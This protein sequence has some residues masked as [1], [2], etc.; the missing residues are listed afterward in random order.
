MADT[1]LISFTS[2]GQDYA[3]PIS[4]VREV[5][6]V[7]RVES[8]PG[9]R[10]PLE[11]IVIYRENQILPV[12]SLPQVLGES[13]EVKGNF[14]VVVEIEGHTLGFRIERIGGVADYP[15]AEEIEEYTGT[16]N[17]VPGAIDGSWKS[18]RGTLLL[19]QLER[20]LGDY[21]A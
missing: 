16:L 7:D 21:I 9:S 3:V 19:L 15:S 13:T 4:A 6:R 2:A 1:R 12:F 18:G 11:G 20:A 14:V 8:V 17:A 10:P 5:L